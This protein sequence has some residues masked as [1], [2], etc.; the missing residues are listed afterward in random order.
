MYEPGR[1]GLFYH[2]NG[3]REKSV[4]GEREGRRDPKLRG[5][6]SRHLHHAEVFLRDQM[7]FHTEAKLIASRSGEDQRRDI[8]P[9]IGNLKAVADGNIRK[10]G[11][12]NKLFAVE[13]DQIDVEVI[14]PFGIGETEI[15]SHL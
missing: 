3:I 11:S 12:A 8:D 14:R 4:A 10:G 5:L 13:V 2:K 9:K 15:Q 6:V 7:P 1:R